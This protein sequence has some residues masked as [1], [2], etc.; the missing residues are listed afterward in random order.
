MEHFLTG[1]K[2]ILTFLSKNIKVF[3]CVLKPKFL[4]FMTKVKP[5]NGDEAKSDIFPYDIFYG[6]KILKYFSL[7]EKVSTIN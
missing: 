7:I 2:Q 6:R 3:Q 5:N 4:S 1:H